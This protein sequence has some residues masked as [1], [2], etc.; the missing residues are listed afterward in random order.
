M[1]KKKSGKNGDYPEPNTSTRKRKRRKPRDAT[2][3]PGSGS[4][5][6][7]PSSPASV[8][9]LLEPY[10]KPRLVAFLAGEA[11]GDPALLA[12]VRAAADASPSHRRIFVHGLPPH[13]DGPALQAAFSA[14]GL[15]SDCHVLADRASGR[16]RGYGFLTF[17]CRSAA[18][19]AVR[20]PCAIVAGRP[21][22]AQLASAGPDPSG[23][24]AAGRRVY[25]TNVAPDASAERLGAFFA[26]FGELQGGP[27]G[28]DAQ[29][30]SSRGY[31]MFLYRAAEGARKLL[32]EPYRVFDGRTLHCQLAADPARKKSKPSPASSVAAAAST[33]LR[34]VLDAVAAAGAGDLAM[35]ARNPAQAAALLGQNP[36]LAAAALSSALAS[37]GVV[38][39]PAAPTAAQS[40]AAF[41]HVSCP[42]ATA[43]ATRSPSGPAVAPPPVKVWSRPNGAAGLLGPYKPPSSHLQRPSSP[44][45]KWAMLGN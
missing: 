32:E 28:F 29:T 20:A 19:R 30:G 14:F 45:R 17:L 34:P 5:S 3:D 36:V 22:S 25:V 13:A 2:P 39:S 9:R 40:P 26:R 21:V 31:A 37:T 1:G 12:R 44:G 42:V 38:L 16:C 8:R 24:A 15:L 33:A 10:S 27:F 35:Y 11:A 4:E 41:S 23:A 18:L 7:P 6:S 43:A